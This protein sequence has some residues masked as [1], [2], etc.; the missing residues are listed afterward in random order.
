MAQIV[1]D[2]IDLVVVQGAKSA[3]MRVDQ[4]LDPSQQIGVVDH[5]ELTDDPDLKYRQLGQFDRDMIGLA[6]KYQLF[7]SA[8]TRLLCENDSDK[9]IV[10]P[11]RSHTDYPVAAP[12]GK[13]R[14]IFTADAPCYGGH[15]RLVDNQV[16][17]TL[18]KPREDSKN[19]YLHLY[20]PSRTALVLEKMPD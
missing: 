5:A 7:S 17:F 16:H 20:L 3:P 19:T 8:D 2:R 11:H 6:K 10:F 9:V 14:M 13:Y 18:D 15:G 1:E 4:A 12:P